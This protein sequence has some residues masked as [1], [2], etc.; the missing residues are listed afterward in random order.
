M[1]FKSLILIAASVGL[2]SSAF[3]QGEG[4]EGR[5]GP[6]ERP[7]PTN[8]I[9]KFDKD[10]DGA[11]NAEELQAAMD[12]RQER[13]EGVRG[14]MHDRKKEFMEK[15]DT[16]KDGKLS[17]DE[18]AALPEEVKERMEERGQKH[19]NCECGAGPKG[20]D[21]KGKHEGH[22]DGGKKGSEDSE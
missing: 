6:Q 20:R 3:A 19:R 17:D 22:R 9:E 2:G 10:G 5:K 8:I 18:K 12:A 16:D 21:H 15:F 11:L 1:K 7:T 14:K 4:K 13:M